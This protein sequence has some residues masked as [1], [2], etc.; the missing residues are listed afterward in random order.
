MG[1]GYVRFALVQQPEVLRGVV[2]KIQDFL[3]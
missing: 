1:E 2:R 3:Q